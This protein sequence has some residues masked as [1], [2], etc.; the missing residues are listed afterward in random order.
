MVESCSLSLG[1]G[2]GEVCRVQRK[3]FLLT[4]TVTF[5]FF[6]INPKKYFKKIIS[7]HAFISDNFII[8]ASVNL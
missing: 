3:G 1:E 4:S 7:F 5:L 6:T 2:R 8:F